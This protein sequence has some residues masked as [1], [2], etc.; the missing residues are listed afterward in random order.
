MQ[1][2]YGSGPI[3]LKSAYI[4]PTMA[5]SSLSVGQPAFVP[6]L[7]PPAASVYADPRMAAP[8]GS[9]PLQFVTP[10]LHP[11]AVT[12]MPPG[13]FTPSS[14]IGN[15]SGQSFS[16]SRAQSSNAGFTPS[17]SFGSRNSTGF[18]PSSSRQ[19]ARGANQFNT[20]RNQLNESQPRYRL[21]A[22]SGAD[23]GSASSSSERVK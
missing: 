9:A 15:V 21:Q 2:Q 5:M 10:M 17:S 1:S 14:S 3:P 7:F 8:Y 4:D 23:S 20:R 22:S 16:T 18:Q 12:Q 6:T 11:T 19:Y 13:F